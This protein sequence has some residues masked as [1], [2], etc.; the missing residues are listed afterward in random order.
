MQVEISMMEIKNLFITLLSMFLLYACSPD[1]EMVI[2]SDN[3]DKGHYAVIE[4]FVDD[5]DAVVTHDGYVCI[6]GIEK[7]DTIEGEYS[8]IFYISK[9]DY[10]TGVVDTS[11]DICVIADTL[12]IPNIISMKGYTVFITNMT[13]STFDCLI[14][15]DGKTPL[16]LTNLSTSTLKSSYT[17]SIKTRSIASS[18]TIPLY[19][20]DNLIDDIGRVQALQAMIT[21]ATNREKWSAGIGAIGAAL[22]GEVGLGLGA[23]SDMLAGSLRNTYL[24][25]AG[26]MWSENQKFILNHI[27]PWRISIESAEQTERKTISVVY[28]IDGIWDACKGQPMI[29]LLCQNIGTKK[30]LPAIELGRA[31]NGIYTCKISDLEPGEYGIEMRVYDNCHKITNISIMT[32]PQIKI[33]VYDFGINRYVVENNPMYSEEKVH[34]DMDVYLDG[35]NSNLKDISQFGYY[36]KFANSIDYHEVKNLSDIF[37]ST[38]LTLDLDIEREGFFKMDYSNF[39]AEATDYYIGAYMV[40]KNGDIQHF[41]EQNIEGLIYNTKP[42]IG[43]NYVSVLGNSVIDSHTYGDGTVAYRYST[44]YTHETYVTG[45]FWISDISSTCSGNYTYEN[46]GSQVSSWGW[47]PKCDGKFNIDTGINFWDN[48]LEPCTVSLQLTLHD[49]SILKADNSLYIKGHPTNTSI[50]IIG[51][52]SIQQ[53]TSVKNLRNTDK[54]KAHPEYVEGTFIRIPTAKKYYRQ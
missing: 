44:S 41:D 15:E 35:D 54:Y 48:Y 20:L 2:S 47:R 45:S 24:A 31:K 46:T 11:E 13:E 16:E 28:I 21:A 40:T 39:I 32:Y 12:G 14:Y 50:S 6:Y 42:S 43:Y 51:S 29:R 52:R 38:P 5:L 17:K 7:N 30:Y 53:N 9:A 25:L 19:G 23:I 8:R 49:G 1:D 37:E 33:N 26:Y 4:N 10:S 3:S 36:V 34:F 27:G 18:E 22:G